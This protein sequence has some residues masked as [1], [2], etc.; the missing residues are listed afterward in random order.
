MVTGGPLESLQTLLHAGDSAGLSPAGRGGE[1]V[2]TGFAPLDSLLPTG[3]VRR[4]GLVEWLAG[5]QASGAATLAAA[6]ACRL[7]GWPAA[8]ASHADR[9]G[10]TAAT[11][12]VVDRRG[13]F[14]PPAVLGWLARAG[15]TGRRPPQLVVARP[16]HEADELWAI[17]QALRCRGVAAVLAWPQAIHST[18]MRRWQLAARASLAVGLFVRPLEARREPSWA[19]ARFAVAARPGGSLAVRRLHVALVGG[20]WTGTAHVEEK[21]IEMGF[22]LARGCEAR[23]P[24]PSSVPHVHGEQEVA[25]CRAS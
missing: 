1:P 9:S 8:A 18:A 4:G 22:D 7:A 17:D 5:D 2:S 20:P 11:I 14:H 3:G 10:E 23:L 21:A 13:W 12:V 6:V 16:A 19:E 24:R 25:A 15:A